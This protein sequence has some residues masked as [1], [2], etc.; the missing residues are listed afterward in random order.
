MVKNSTKNYRTD[1][2]DERVMI[3]L[4]KRLPGKTRSWII[5]TAL[6]N[7]AVEV[8]ANPV[9]SRRTKKNCAGIKLVSSPAKR[10]VTV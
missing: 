4:K 8:G 5:R 6:K 3:A 10:A 9:K 1:E 7:Y 2:D